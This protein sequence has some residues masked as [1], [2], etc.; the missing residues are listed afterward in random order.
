[1]ARGFAIGQVWRPAATGAGTKTTLRE[2]VQ[3]VVLGIIESLQSHDS[4]WMTTNGTIQLPSWGS[5]PKAAPD[6]PTWDHE[7]LAEQARHDIGEIRPLLETVLEPDVLERVVAEVSGAVPALDDELWVTIVYA[8]ASAAHRGGIGVEHLAGMFVPIYL[9][10]AA[11]FIAQTALEEDAKVQAR[12]D[13]LC[14][15]FERLK[16]ALVSGWSAVV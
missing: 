7:A 14:E 15:A 5:D 3:Q 4:F 9:W 2:A 13:S 6:A 8:F 1:M 10:R 12:L 11:A 16:P